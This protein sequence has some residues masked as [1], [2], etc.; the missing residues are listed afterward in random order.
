M[1]IAIDP[2]PLVV[3]IYAYVGELL[4]TAA[5]KRETDAADA[6]GRRLARQRGQADRE[7][8]KLVRAL[9]SDVK[10]ADK[11]LK[12]TADVWKISQETDLVDLIIL[13]RGDDASPRAYVL[14]RPKEMKPLLQAIRAA[15]AGANESEATLG[16]LDEAIESTGGKPS[17]Y[18]TFGFNPWEG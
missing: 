10:T 17:D 12:K 3:G 9:H 7:A 6:L 2:V 1:R 18:L 8:Q 13:P 14:L 16:Q 5:G 15:A 11:L 4:A